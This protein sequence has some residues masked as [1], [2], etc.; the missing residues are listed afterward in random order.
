MVLRYLA[1]Q[2]IK[3]GSTLRISGKVGKP[4]PRVVY[5]FGE[6]SH[7]FKEFLRARRFIKRMVSLI[8]NASKK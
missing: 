3:G 6:Q 4:S 7:A 5:R 2:C 8:Q 1:M